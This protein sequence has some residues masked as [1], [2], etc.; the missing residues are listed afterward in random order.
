MHLGDNVHR[1]EFSEG[2]P[3]PGTITQGVQDVH[4]PLW[5]DVQ[6]HR[7]LPYIDGLQGVAQEHTTGALFGASGLKYGYTQVDVATRCKNDLVK[8]KHDLAQTILT[9]SHPALATY[10]R[11][12]DADAPEFDPIPQTHSLSAFVGKLDPIAPEFAPIS[13]MHSLSGATGFDGNDF[14]TNGGQKIHKRR[15][16]NKG[17]CPR[18]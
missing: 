1:T 13:Q 11:K 15:G 2:D 7:N 6:T 16:D 18:G 3:F 8:G 4:E 10:G 5:R 14:R 17:R 12:L 9:T